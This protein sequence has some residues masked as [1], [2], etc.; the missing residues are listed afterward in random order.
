MNTSLQSDYLQGIAVND[1]AT[2]QKI[3]KESLPEVAK[4]VKKNSG[5]F[6]DAKDVFQEGIM[7]I[8]RKI[9]ADAL[10]LTTSFHVYLFSVCKKIWLKKLSRKSGK[11]V[12]LDFVGDFA[13]EEN[14]DADITKARK[15]ALFNKH[16]QQLAEECRKVLKLFFNG[17]S[18]KEIAEEMDYTEEYAKRK[19][20]KCKIGLTK[21]IKEDPEY[22]SL[23]V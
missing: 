10:T 2:L 20:Y 15:W 21:L 19:K 9:K 16:L 18:S 3:Y 11:S 12:P 4:Y 6:E 23:I 13:S 22:K 17:R 5:S 8:Y 7:V 14:L 1:F